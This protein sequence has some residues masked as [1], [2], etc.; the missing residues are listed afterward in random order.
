MIKD[1]QPNQNDTTG[2]TDLV[3]VNGTLF[4]S[5]DDGIHGRE[6][7]KLVTTPTLSAQLS[8]ST[9]FGNE[10]IIGDTKGIYNNITISHEGSNLVITDA[11]EPFITAPIGATL[12][13]GGKILTIP[14]NSVDILDIRTGAD[15][16]L[17]NIDTRS[18]LAINTIVDLGTGIDSINLI[19][20]NTDNVWT[21][22][23]AQQGGLSIG[24]LGGVAFYGLEYAQGG[25]GAD[26]FIFAGK[27]GIVSVD[28]D[29]GSNDNTLVLPYLVNCTVSD[30]RLIVD[31]KYSVKLNNIQ[32]AKNT[33]ESIRF[34]KPLFFDARLFS[35]NTFIHGGDGNDTIYG[36]S[37]NDTIFGYFG[38]DLIVAGAGDD[39]ID[40]YGSS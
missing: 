17:V 20:N 19:S 5:V 30:T 11:N 18:N 15:D 2:P 27:P 4:F 32:V 21:F 33:P 7:W 16:D 34:T 39:A 24:S 8:S 35:G 10:L 13:N 3:N 22:N 36:G 40:D 25:S 12:S 37:G 31:K 6:L 28:G 26:Q 23:G 9:T 38:K 1:I 14:F 29:F